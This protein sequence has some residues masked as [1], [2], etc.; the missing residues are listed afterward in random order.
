MHV[1]AVTLT[2]RIDALLIL[3]MPAMPAMPAMS[4]TVEFQA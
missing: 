2:I 3:A 1:A 4:M